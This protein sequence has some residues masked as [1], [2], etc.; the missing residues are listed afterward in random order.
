MTWHKR[1]S[2][3]ARA[4]FLA[5]K[6]AGQFVGPLFHACKDSEVELLIVSKVNKPPVIVGWVVY[7]AAVADRV[8][9]SVVEERSNAIKDIV[10]A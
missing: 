2:R 9:S 8:A 1:Y 7:E 5:Y 4:L 3:K 10:D 6:K